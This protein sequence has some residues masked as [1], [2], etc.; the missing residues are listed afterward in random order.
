MSDEDQPAQPP[1]TGPAGREYS[2]VLRITGGPFDVML[3]FG[4]QQPA[5]EG[6]GQHEPEVGEVARISMSWGHAKSMI[7][8]LARVVADYESKFGEV[9][10]PGFENNWRA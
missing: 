3:I 7:P 1:W 9:P 6:A 5:P 2:N 4:L 8:L 10:A